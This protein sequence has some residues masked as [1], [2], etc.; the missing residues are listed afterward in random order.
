VRLILAENGIN[1]FVPMA[2]TVAQA[3]EYLLE[4]PVFI[5]GR[6]RIPGRR[7]NDCYL[8]MRKNPL[9]KGIFAVTLI[10]AA[11]TLDCKTDKKTETIK[12]KNWGKMIALQPVTAFPI[13]QNNNS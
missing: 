9:A 12:S 1:A 11:M 8:V 7:T 6:I 3:I 2:K 10:K 13:P 4:K 5:F